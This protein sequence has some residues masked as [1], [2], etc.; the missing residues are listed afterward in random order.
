MDR[1]T[2]VEGHNNYFGNAGSTPDSI[3]N[4]SQFDGLFQYILAT[5]A[6]AS[7]SATSPT[8]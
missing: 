1:L 2:N 3:Y 6:S 4:T 8:A 7:R 5:G